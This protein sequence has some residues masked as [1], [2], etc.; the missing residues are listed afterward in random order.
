MHNDL[1]IIFLTI[2]QVPEQ[3]ARYQKSILLEAIGDTPVITI[4]RLPLDWGTNLIQ[5]AEPSIPNI[6]RQILRG[7]K[8]AITPYIGIAEDDNLYHKEH[9]LYRPPDMNT[10]AYDGHRWGIFTWGPPTYYHKDR[11][12]NASMIAPRELVVKSLEERFRRYPNTNIGELG[13]EKGTVLD[14]H[15]TVIYWSTIGM[16]FFSHVN[17][18]DHLERTKRKRMGMVRAFDI[19]YWG[20]SEELIK[21]FV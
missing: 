19:P 10:Y 21:H 17:A 14:R 13:K 20:R 15:N 18:L 5:D 8:L 16:V 3:W 7:S 2:N 9:F 12:V 1:T 4:S 11:I 6:Y